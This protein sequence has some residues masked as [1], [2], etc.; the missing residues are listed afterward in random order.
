MYFII[1]HR[2]S[3]PSKRTVPLVHQP[4]KPNY[5]AP[6][7]EN[8]KKNRNKTA[9]P[10]VALQT[11]CCPKTQLVCPDSQLKTDF[12]NCTHHPGLTGPLFPN[13]KDSDGKPVSPTWYK[14]YQVPVTPKWQQDVEFPDGSIGNCNLARCDTPPSM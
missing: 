13:L 6:T 2:G 5:T 14:G 4:S 10:F 9:N 7:I 12:E 1:M 8:D 11:K 3:A